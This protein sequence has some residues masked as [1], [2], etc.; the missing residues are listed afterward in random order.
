MLFPETE[1]DLVRMYWC[2]RCHRIFLRGDHNV[3]CCVA[4]ASG[5][6]CHYGDMDVSREQAE[7]VCILLNVPAVMERARCG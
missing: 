6:C 4:H 7:Q 5:T 3:S 2:P 1:C